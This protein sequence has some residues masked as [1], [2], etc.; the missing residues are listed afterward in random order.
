[1]TCTSCGADNPEQSRFCIQ[2]G[3][4]LEEA[5]PPAPAAPQTTPGAYD[6]QPTSSEYS[7]GA[8]PAATT[9]H[10]P[11]APLYDEVRHAGFLIRFVAFVLDWI[12][13]YVV[14]MIVVLPMQL[15]SGV[16]AFNMDG[17]DVEAAEFAKLFAVVGISVVISIVIQWLYEAVL[18]SS[19][20]QATFGK[21][22]FGLRVTDLSGERLTFGRAT[23]RHFAKWISYFT[24][25]I[26]YLIQPITEKKQAL[27]DIIAGTL[28]VKKP[29]R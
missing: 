6:P 26:G 21:Q 5:A 14:Q 16:D 29:L 4:A 15:L 24:F 3:S 17:S 13:L 28:V 7:V 18:L 23:G 25:G 27:H 20:N 9:P 10:D 2:C 11:V 12:L 1:M 22:A 8:A 19:V